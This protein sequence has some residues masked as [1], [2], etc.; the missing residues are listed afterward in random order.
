METATPFASADGN[1]V[2]SRITNGKPG[3]QN[4]PVGA[5]FVLAVF[6]NL[7]MESQF[8]GKV[9]SL[10]IFPPLAF[11]ANYF[12]QGNNVDIHLVQNV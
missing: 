1:I 3:K 7:H 4:V 10:I 12:L 5:A 8:L 2:V 11:D 6:T 9:L